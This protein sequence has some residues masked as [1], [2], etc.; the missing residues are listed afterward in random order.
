MATSLQVRERVRPSR[1]C[2]KK[3]DR[4]AILKKQEVKEKERKVREVLAK[5]AKLRTK[6]DRRLLRECKDVAKELERRARLK[7]MVKRKTLEVEDSSDVLEAKV[8]ELVSAIKRSKH[9]VV[10]TGAG[11][12]TAASI[13]DYRGPSGVWTLLQKGQEVRTKS[14]VDAD[15]TL[16]HMAITE[17]QRQGVVQH[18][19]S[20][21]CDGLH[22][23]SG[24][25]QRVL[26]EVHG[27][28]FI[29][30]CTECKPEVEYVRLFDVTERTACRR[31]FTGRFCHTCGGPL[32]DSI[33]HFGEKGAVQQPLNWSGA[34]AAAKET[35]M[36]LCLGSSLKVLKRY[37]CL[38]GTSRVKSKQPRLYIVNLQWTPKDK[39]AV[40]KVH[41]KCDSVMEKVM[42]K[43]ELKIP[44]YKR[45]HD[46]IFTMATPLR[47]QEL[48]TFS[49]K[50]LQPLPAT[51]PVLQEPV[52]TS[53]GQKEPVTTGPSH[54]SVNTSDSLVTAQSS[55]AGTVK[56]ELAANAKRDE[57]EELPVHS[58]QGHS[59]AVLAKPGW[60]G[61]GYHR[62]VTRSRKRRKLSQDSA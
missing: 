44:K 26:S 60:F 7:E 29:E 1:N 31:H 38:W 3:T 54:V 12:S 8:E 15:P 52:Q 45:S 21:N 59:A 49:T 42:A 17:L 39:M 51:G 48:D 13:P 43:L 27:N 4:S 47:K 36:I 57:H 9:P 18:V 20:Q 37:T 34:V 56:A 40:L 6:D 50:L 25:P 10:Y 33:V 61:K 24:L 14:L 55:D 23:R 16:T 30:V 19:V 28:M 53:S 2:A 58:E 41:G 5:P 35:D 46:P 22:L 11:I 62:K 32:R